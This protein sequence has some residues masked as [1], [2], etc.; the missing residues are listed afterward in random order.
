MK[1]VRRGIGT[2]TLGLALAGL[3]S[4][5]AGPS[6]ANSSCRAYCA[7]LCQALADCE[8]GD[9]PPSCATDCAAQIGNADCSAARPPGQLT[10][11]ELGE[12]YACADYCAT[13]CTRA[14]A[15]G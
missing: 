9:I 6:D 5:C 8:V 11:E 10:C 12:E 14:T 7:D 4:T 2:L 13:F 1:L 3:L 15:C